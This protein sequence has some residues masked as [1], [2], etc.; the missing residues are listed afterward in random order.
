MHEDGWRMMD[1]SGNRIVRNAS[2]GNAAPRP[3]AL[4]ASCASGPLVGSPLKPRAIL[5]PHV[6]PQFMDWR[7]L[8]STDYIQRHGLMR[9]AA[10]AFH[11]EIKV[12][13]VECVAQRR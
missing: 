5:A 4:P 13:G 12:A 6:A 1:A 10:Q 7:S 9:A 3:R 8:R 11:F 2:G